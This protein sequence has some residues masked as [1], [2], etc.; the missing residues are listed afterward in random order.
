MQTL[1]LDDRMKRYEGVSRIYLP[2]RIP[3]I[4]R[5]DG[6]AFHTFT[7]TH[8][9]K[10]YNEEF[11]KLMAT[12]AIETMSE[13]QGCD[14]CYTQS[15]EISFLLTDYQTIQTEPWFGY[16]LQ[17]MVSISAALASSSF[18]RY[19]NCQVLFDSRAFSIPIDEV[20]NYFIWR[21]QDA[22]RNAI[23]MLGQELFSHNQLHEKN[24]DQIQDMVFKEHGINFNDLPI[25]RKR[26]VAITKKGI[27]YEIPIFT[28]DRNYVEQYVNV[29]ED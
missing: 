26:G 29:K 21:Q 5:V 22:T 9:G 2:R 25:M 24:T 3:V 17:K 1:S 16:N 7:R 6:K 15:D 11:I 4:I 18:S 19:M 13:I 12:V 23:L 20:T 14:L 27:D 8:W 28:Q 10:H